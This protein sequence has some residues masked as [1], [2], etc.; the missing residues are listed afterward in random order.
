MAP[1]SNQTSIRSGSRNIFSPLGDTNT[2]SS[3]YGLCRSTSFPSKGEAFIKPFERELAISSFNSAIEPMHFSSNPSSVLQIG[4]GVPQNLERLRFQSTKFS[5]QLP[6][7]P[8]PVASGFQ[9]IVLFNSTSL[10][11]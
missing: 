11:L 10:S 3:T 6:N 8:I 9:L 5:N 7:L 4:R 2:T 1:E